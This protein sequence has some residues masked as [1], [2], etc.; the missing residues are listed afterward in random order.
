M[1][2]NSLSLEEK[3]GQM[4]LVAYEENTITEEL[5]MLIQK[6]KIGG[7]ILY[8]KKF[9][10]YQDLVKFINEIKELNKSNPLPLF[11]SIDQEGG[12]V[13]RLPNEIS[14]LKPPFELAKSNNINTI[15]NATYITSKI[16]RETGY[17]MNFAPVL[18]IKN[19][20]EMHSI[21]NRCYGENVDDVSKFGICAMKVFQTN[22][23]IPV[24][25]HFPRSWCYKN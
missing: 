16:L 1:D 17:N 23:I 10:Q 22:N 2:I 9:I 7:I 6:Y 12:R 20:D 19:F 5:K 11:I 24:V 15:K 3:I 21:G 25:K 18:D 4:F 14:N 8:R 13:N